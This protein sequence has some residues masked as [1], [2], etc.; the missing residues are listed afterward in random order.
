MLDARLKLINQDATLQGLAYMYYR[1]VAPCAS[2]RKFVNCFWTLQSSQPVTFY[3]RTFPDGCQEIVFNVNATVRRSDNGSDYSI[4]PDAELIGQMTRPYDLITHG[5][6]TY[7]GIKFYP[8]SFA[9][10]TRE[11]IHDLRDQSID[12]RELFGGDFCR[13]IDTVFETPDFDHFVSLLEVWLLDNLCENK[14]QGRA[15]KIVDQAVNELLV[16]KV[17]TR[18]DELHQKLDIGTRYFQSLFKTYVGLA[19]RQLYKMIRFQTCFQDLHQQH[20][21]LTDVAMRR[22]YY[23][24]AHFAHD[25][26]EFSGM[27]PSD[28]RKAEMPLNRFFLDTSSRAWLCNYKEQL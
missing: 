19:P 10:F 3:D 12:L 8:H 21:S 13:V 15:Y 18:M 2:L 26:R 20:L 1:E 27:A 22:G 9:A 28:Y 16:K 17:H 6:Q 23:D 14:I 7:F 4:N 25:F 11:S 5:R 24:Q